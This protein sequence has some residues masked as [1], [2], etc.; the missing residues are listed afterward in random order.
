MNDAH[1]VLGRYA[2]DDTSEALVEVRLLNF[3]LPLFL[4]AR[5]RHDGLVREF[6]LLAIHPPQSRPGHEVPARLI[7]LIE[8]LGREYGGAADRADA[9]RD[10]AVERGDLSVDLTYHLPP[11]AATG[12]EHLHQLTDDADELCRE[13]HLLTLPASALE[14]RFRHWYLEQFTAQL[15]GDPPTPWDGPL[16]DEVRNR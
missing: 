12:L 3:P 13:E 2:A 14:Q 8:T 6:A 4:Q 10:A 9:V 16:V 11:S 15:K 1:S 5:E 7:S